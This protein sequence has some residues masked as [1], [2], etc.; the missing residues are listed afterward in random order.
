[1][2]MQLSNG[3]IITPVKGLTYVDKPFQFLRV[4]HKIPNRINLQQFRVLTNYVALTVGNPM[5]SD[6]DVEKY[7]NDLRRLFG[8]RGNTLPK[9]KLVAMSKNE[10]NKRAGLPPQGMNK[11]NCCKECANKTETNINCGCSYDGTGYWCNG[12]YCSNYPYSSDCCQCVGMGGFH[13]C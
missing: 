10:V 2:V 4:M 12:T 11:T 9:G 3:N 8:V 6:E 13:H 7:F 5:V 1:M